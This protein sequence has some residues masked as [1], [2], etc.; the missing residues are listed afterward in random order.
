MYRRTKPQANSNC[1]QMIDELSISIFK[2]SKAQM[3][4]L[5]KYWANCVGIPSPS[6]GPR[7]RAWE[8]RKLIIRLPE[9]PSHSLISDCGAGRYFRTVRCGLRA[10]GDHRHQSDGNVRDRQLKALFKPNRKYKSSRRV[11]SLC[12][13]K[14][15]SLDPVARAR[16]HAE[17]ASQST[18]W[19]NFD[20]IESTQRLGL[21]PPFV[22]RF[23]FYRMRKVDLSVF[24]D[25]EIETEAGIRGGIE[26]KICVRTG[27]NKIEN[28]TGIG[29]LIELYEFPKWPE[30]HQQSYN[31]RCSDSFTRSSYVR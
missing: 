13:R 20:V 30:M 17:C 31:M 19:I 9:P 10:I 7:A 6:T 26:S 12:H 27:N 8:P 11:C 5:G 16:Q 2:V 15:I 22:R 14:T 1:Y 4:S 18:K 21:A 3:S 25:I 28:T 29:F 24:T 23:P